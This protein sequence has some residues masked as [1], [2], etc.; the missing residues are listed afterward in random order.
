MFMQ[1]VYEFLSPA[2]KVWGKIMFLHVSVI[3]STVILSIGGLHLGPESLYPGAWDLYPGL[4][5][6]CMDGGG[7]HLGLEGSPSGSG[8]LCPG[9]GVSICVWGLSI[10]GLHLGPEGLY[11]GALDLYQGLEGLCLGLGV[12]IWVWA[13]PSG[14]GGSPSGSD[15]QAGSTHPT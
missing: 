6:L 10:G 2:N 12:S 11:P 9:L 5:G 1:E 7:F 14:S 3:L 13:S 15:Q 8:G 4:E